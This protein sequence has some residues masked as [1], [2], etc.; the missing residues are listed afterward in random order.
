MGKTLVALCVS[1]SEE[2]KPFI[3]KGDVTVC[4]YK[5]IKQS[6]VSTHCHTR[7]KKSSLLLIP[8]N[9]SVEEELINVADVGVMI[10]QN[11]K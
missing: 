9:I 11:R 10:S 3:E 7:E 1:V 6:Y 8:E 2:I 4:L 5:S